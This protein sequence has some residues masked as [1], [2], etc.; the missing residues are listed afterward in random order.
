MEKPCLYLPLPKH[1]TENRGIHA[2]FGHA[3]VPMEVHLALL[4]GKYIVQPDFG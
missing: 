2:A 4:I 1:T 3:T